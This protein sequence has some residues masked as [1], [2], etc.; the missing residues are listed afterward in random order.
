MQ[1]CN[2]RRW[3]DTE[4]VARSEAHTPNQLPA[5]GSSSPLNEG[6]ALAIGVLAACA[7][8]RLATINLSAQGV[9]YDEIHQAPAAFACLG[10]KAPFFAMSFVHR[11]PLMTMTYSG[12][13]KPILYGLYLRFTGASFSVESWRWLGIA[14]VAA[15]FPLFSMLA[16]RRLSNVGL[17]TFFALILTDATVVLET[18][19]DWGPTAL[20]LAL[21]MIFLGT[22]LRGAV[23]ETVR[24]RNSFFLGLIVGFSIYEKL[25]NI[26]LLLPLGL[27]LVGRERRRLDHWRA[28]LVGGVVGALPLLY[29]NY[30]YF[31]RTGV[32][33]STRQ[34]EAQ[35]DKSLAGVVHFLKEYLSL[36]SGS[37]VRQFIL[38]EN[39]GFAVAEALLLTA[40]L[41]AVLCLWKSV[42]VSRT[43]AVLVACYL[44]AGVGLFL[45]PNVTAA[46]HWVIGTPFQYLAF[47]M[48]IA[49]PYRRPTGTSGLAIASRVAL[50]LVLGALMVVRAQG[51]TALTRSLARG[52]SSDAWDPSLTRLGEFCASRAG[53]DVF[54]AANW[55]VATQIFC[56]SDGHPHVVREWWAAP[57]LA[58]SIRLGRFRS[59]Y[60]VLNLHTNFPDSDF[61]RGVITEFEK[62]PRL[63][64]VPVEQELAELAAVKVRKFVYVEDGRRHQ[65]VLKRSG[66]STD[67]TATR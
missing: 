26:V 37:V 5:G 31:L 50:I 21:R 19:H 10:K 22:W 27:I 29:V 41:I 40:A 53:Q 25:S 32:L 39:H 61:S 18:R 65:I 49:A 23:H 44:A 7:F 24:P 60:V 33:F 45:L 15:T 48:A 66:S 8:A 6:T 4:P 54:L 14:L 51:T 59:L 47:A 63:V 28:C 13:I 38:G 30:Q 36:G 56:L 62:H 34:V 3:Q 57:A 1:E 42:A 20:A 58:K 43:P 35:G 2:R 17:V 55:G 67:Q 9:Y 11:I 46:H 52:A 64:E 12:A 16:R